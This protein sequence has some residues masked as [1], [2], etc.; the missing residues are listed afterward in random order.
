MQGKEDDGSSVSR[1]V[2][3]RPQNTRGSTNFWVLQATNVML[4]LDSMN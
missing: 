4:V 3:Y 1:S 2:P